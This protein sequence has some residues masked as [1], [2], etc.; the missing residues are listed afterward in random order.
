MVGK[1]DPNDLEIPHLRMTV[2]NSQAMRTRVNLKVI[3]IKAMALVASEG[4]DGSTEVKAICKRNRIQNHLRFMPPSLG[5]A[6]NSDMILRTRD[7]HPIGLNRMGGSKR[8]TK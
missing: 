7:T 3:I 5:Q 6:R 8:R 4:E 2:Q 1:E